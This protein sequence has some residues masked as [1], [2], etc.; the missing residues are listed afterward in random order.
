VVLLSD[1][2]GWLDL[3]APFR[4]TASWDQCGLQIG[5]PQASVKRI[6]VA[7]DPGTT[8]LNE[9]QERECQCLVT[10][11]PLLFQPIKAVRTDQ[12][13]GNLVIEAVRKGIGVISAHTNLDIVKGGINDQLGEMLAVNMTG[14]LEWD[15]AWQSEPRYGGMGR[16]GFLGQPMSFRALV[17]ETVKRLGG[18]AVRAVG[19]GEKRVHRVALCSGSGGSLIEQAVGAGSDV[20]ITGDVKYHDAQR[21][22]EAG[23]ALIDIGHFASERI[24]V[25]PLAAF[26]RAQAAARCDTLEVIEAAVERDPFWQPPINAND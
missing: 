6:L 3:Y 1:I 2:L 7:L 5:D 10:H 16:I 14:P 9:A 22:V 17:E 13:P 21:A 20:F 18:I 23:L 8:T 24:I 11:H 4:Y 25:R 15:V 12:F 19:N 26:I